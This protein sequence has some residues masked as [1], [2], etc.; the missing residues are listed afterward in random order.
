MASRNFNFNV[1]KGIS[2]VASSHGGSRIGSGREKLNKIK[3]T[4]RLAPDVVIFLRGADQPA[5]QVIEKAVR[6][7]IRHEVKDYEL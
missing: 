3:V 7:L 4:Y 1:N 5:S 6:V 2:M